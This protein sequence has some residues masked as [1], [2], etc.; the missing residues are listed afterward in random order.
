MNAAKKTPKKAS[1]AKKADTPVFVADG[2]FIKIDKNGRQV[3]S[4]TL[5][6]GEKKLND[7]TTRYRAD[8]PTTD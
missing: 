5:Y 1:P 4:T 7:T 8:I 3:L 6:P 2:S